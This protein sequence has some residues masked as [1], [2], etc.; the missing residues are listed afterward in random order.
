MTLKTLASSALLLALALDLASSRTALGAV[1]IAPSP[2][3]KESD[4]I[5][6]LKSDAPSAEK[7]ITC[8]Q[9][10]IWGGKDAVP[11]LAPLLLD[12]QLTSWARTALEAIPDPSA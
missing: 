8:K 3:P 5:Q 9:L 6:V 1:G 12:P 10:A 7:A 2:A 11:A 4:L